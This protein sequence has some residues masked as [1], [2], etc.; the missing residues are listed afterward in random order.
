MTPLTK[1][2]AEIEER[3]H[4]A[5]ELRALV[6]EHAEKWAKLLPGEQMPY[7]SDLLR[8]ADKAEDACL[9]AAPADL[10]YLAKLVRM[11]AEAECQAKLRP[12]ELVM[13]TFEDT[14]RAWEK[15]ACV[16]C[17]IRKAGDGA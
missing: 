3:L 9:K 15:Y 14:P 6:R 7:P 4:L 17:R 2:L 13:R 12:C 8:R 10:A 16:P 5:D 1:R 11:V